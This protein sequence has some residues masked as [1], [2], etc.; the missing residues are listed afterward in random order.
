MRGTITTFMMLMLTTTALAQL[1]AASPKA[2]KKLQVLT[3]VQIDPSRLLPPP[4]AD[5]SPEHQKEMANVKAVIQSRTRE[6]YAQAVWDAEHEDATLFAPTLGPAFDLGKLPATARLLATIQNDQALAASAA[7]DFFK[8]KF[9]VAAE[10]PTA[11]RDWTCDKDDRK[12]ATRPLRSYPSGHATLGYSMAS[13]LAALM[14]DKAQAILVRAQD[15]AFSREVCG[16][17]YHSDVEASHALG[18][19]LGAMF[20]ESAALKPQL[21]AARAEL[22]AAHLTNGSAMQSAATGSASATYSVTHTYELGGDGR[23]DYIVADPP[24]HRVFIGRTN[25]VMVVD[26][27]KGTLIGEVK[28]V[29]GAHGTAVVPASGHGF[30]TSGND[31]QVIMFDLQTFAELRRIPAAEDADAIIYDEPSNRVFTFNGDAHSSTVIDPREGAVVANVPLGGKPEYGASAGDGKIY[32]NL[33]DTSE[34]VE[35]DAKNAKVSRRWAT[36]ECKQPVAMAIDTTHHRL[37][38]GCRSGV[39]AVSDYEAGRLIATAPIG[40]GVDGAAY[41]AAAGEI[42]LS[43]ADGTLTVVHQDSADAYH[44]AQTLTTPEGSRNLGLDPLTHRVF[45]AAAKFG[46]VPAGSKERPA[47]LP[48]SFSLLVIE[49]GS[50]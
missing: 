2:V 31:G 25:R 21:D 22:Q 48:G 44:V 15:Y 20:L 3:T 47:V 8:R 49:R 13:V 40:K 5:G 17:H 10:M 32:A 30:A 16:D 19:A 29:R 24:H 28:G 45:V 33:T 27:E 23:W 11:Y 46:S 35:I 26:E 9:P 37:F 12:P 42:F 14:P 50:H 36:G 4:A 7:K 38:S 43:N 6:R 39:V 34:I 41:D 18:S 1:P